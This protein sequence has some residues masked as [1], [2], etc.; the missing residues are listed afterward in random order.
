M[1]YKGKNSRDVAKNKVVTEHIEQGRELGKIADEVGYSLRQLSRF[2][3]EHMTAIVKNTELTQLEI[4]AKHRQRIQLLTD[5][6]ERHRKANEPLPLDCIAE[7]RAL[8][9]LE[10]KYDEP[11]KSISAHVSNNPEHSREYLLFKK[12]TADLDAEQLEEVYKF[13]SSLV[14]KPV[15]TV[16]DASWYPAPM[17]PLLEEG[18][19]NEVD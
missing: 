10:M 14:R 8:L 4:R 6:V 1:R 12:H 16:R 9:A 17:R 15:V 18:E 3:K 5:E 2:K 11:T 7:M 13:A 19:P